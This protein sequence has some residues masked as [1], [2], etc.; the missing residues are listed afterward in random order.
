M[1]VVK[2]SASG[3][4]LLS[5]SHSLLRSPIGLALDSYGFL[6]VS[7]SSV[8]LVLKFTSQGGY[9]GAFVPPFPHALNVPTTGTTA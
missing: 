6:Y 3:A 4:V 5:I 1:R 2:V 7:S 8:N 9:V